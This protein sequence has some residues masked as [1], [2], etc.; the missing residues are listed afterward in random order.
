ML[1]H[2]YAVKHILSNGG[3]SDDFRFT[4][5]F[6]Q[7]L[8][9]TARAKLLK[10][11]LSK[12][13][14][15]SDNNYQSLCVDLELTK[16]HN[17]ECISKEYSCN[18]LKSKIKIPNYITVSDAS[19]IE[20][21]TIDGTVISPTSKKQFELSGNSI[22][23]KSTIGWY[24]FNGYLYITNNIILK[25][26]LVN[27]L[28]EDTAE[29]KKCQ[30]ESCTTDC[31]DLPDFPIDPDLV[32]YVYDLVT[33]MLINRNATDTENNANDDTSS[34]VQASGSQG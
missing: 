21:T 25:T 6:I 8:L 11:R 17:C 7:H 18:I 26:V 3:I 12:Y 19:S 22:T 33:K 27:A 16:F 23:N 29:A 9:L 10:D 30:C 32:I 28:F 4:D 2:I 34:S 24:I 20:V 15:V 1:K 13:Q 5:L 31:K 14:K